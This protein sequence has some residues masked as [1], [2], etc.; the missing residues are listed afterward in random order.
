MAE[1]VFLAL[2]RAEGLDPAE[3]ER[4]FG[5]A[6][7]SVFE[8]Q[9]ADCVHRGWLERRRDG[10]LA[11]TADGRMWADEVGAAFV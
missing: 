6:P 2:R 8:T 5:R 7:E 11:L 4:A 1:T 10:R 9:I 3:F